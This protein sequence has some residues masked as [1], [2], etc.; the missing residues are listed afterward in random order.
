MMD[1][2]SGFLAMRG[3][4][5]TVIAYCGTRGWLEYTLLPMR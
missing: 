1:R 4:P 2:L 5:H 3:L